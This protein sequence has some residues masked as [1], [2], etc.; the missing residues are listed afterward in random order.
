MTQEFQALMK[1][2][3]AG[4]LGSRVA[5]IPEDVNWVKVEKLAQDHG[6]QPLVGYALK[7]SPAL[8]CPEEVRK[9]MIGDMRQTAFSNH[10]WKNSTLQLI[11][12][13]RSE[14]IPVLLIKGYS[15][16][17]CYAAPDCRL[18]GDTDLLISSEYENRA[19]KFLETKGFHVKPRWQH[20]HHAVCEHPVIGC[21]ELHVQ[22]YDEFVEDI[23]FKKVDG[24]K[25]ICEEPIT[26][27]MDGYEYA[28]LAPTDHLLFLILHLV[29][30]FIMAGMSLRMMMDVVLFFAKNASY[31][32]S[33]RIWTTIDA[34]GFREI[35]QSIIYAVT[36][37]SDLDVTQVPGCK[38]PDPKHVELLLD[39]L[40]KGG[41]LGSN[42]K[43]AR[44][45]SG[46]EYNRQM[47]TQEKGK[48]AYYCYMAY[49]KVSRVA[50]ALFPPYK[51]LAK[52][53][54]YLKRCPIL[55][56]LAWGQYVV[57]RVKQA[58]QRKFLTRGVAKNEASMSNAGAERV[59]LFRKFGML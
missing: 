28:T 52:Q 35:V 50:F 19:L 11:S 13:M 2:A 46:N 36:Q 33:E 8:S 9:R 56:P 5:S 32:D 55:L 24:K 42:D 59:E 45:E 57:Y 43:Q 1:L 51:V 30:H 34:L 7:L 4:S 53:Y 12:E 31:I 18:S 20:W 40:E 6:V 41:W 23:W 14:G 3:T 58:A 37:N 25:F 16:A 26:V 22:L 29:K 39:D 44:L 47:I 54:P 10:A 15:L 17:S 48:V 27:R 38:H 49:L 21:V